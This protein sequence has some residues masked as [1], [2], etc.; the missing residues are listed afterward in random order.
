M[1]PVG[2]VEA[3]LSK[4][5]YSFLTENLGK[6]DVYW[7]NLFQWIPKITESTTSV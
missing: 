5:S 4:I 1:K 3:Y 7:K 2:V 6:L